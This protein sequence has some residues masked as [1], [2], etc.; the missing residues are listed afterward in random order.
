PGGEPVVVVAVQ[1]D[2]RVRADA[3]VAQELAELLAT[4]DVAPD[5]VRQL[6]RPVPADGARDM[7]LFEGGRVDVDLHETDRRIVEVSLRPV[8]IDEDV[9]GIAG[10]GHGT[11][12]LQRAWRKPWGRGRRSARSSP[13][14]TRTD[15]G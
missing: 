7:A 14:E 12:P 8:G 2:R 1:H 15:H 13:P 4:G 5:T 3:A 11:S 6:A 9:I 10:N